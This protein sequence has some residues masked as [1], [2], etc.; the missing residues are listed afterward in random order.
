MSYFTAKMHQIRFW[1]G[2]RPRPR[3][4]AYSTPQDPLAVFKGPTSKGREGR[5]GER[6]KNEEGEEGKGKEGC[7]GFKSRNGGNPT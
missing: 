6:M 2:M 7:P 5:G 3:W 4:G 1:L